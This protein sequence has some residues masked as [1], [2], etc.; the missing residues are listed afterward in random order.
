MCGNPIST[1]VRGAT[2]VATFGTAE[3]GGIS[4][5]LGDTAGGILGEGKGPPGAPNL[6]NYPGLSP[7]EL[8]AIKKQNISL[9]QLNSIISGDQATID[10][11]KQV[12]QGIS[13]LYNPDGTINQ[14]GLDSLKQRTQ[15]HI[16]LSNQIGDKA[17]GYLQS[18]FAP[19]G[20]GAGPAGTQADINQA[21]NQQ[22]L[23]ALNGKYKASVGLQ[24]DSAQQFKLLQEAAAKR[25]IKIDGDSFDS[26][27]SESTA[28][29][30]MISE[31]QK[32]YARNVDTEKQSILSRGGNLNLGRTQQAQTAGAQNFTL[33]NSV[34]AGGTPEQLGYFSGAGA[35]TSDSLAPV[36]GQ[37]VNGQSAVAN[38]FAQQRAGIYNSYLQQQQ[39]NY[40]AQTAQ[41]QADQ[42]RMGGIG[43]LVGT[44]G[45]A[46]IAGPVG[47]KVGSTVGG[48]A[49]T[50]SSS[51]G[52]GYFT[53]PYQ[54]F[55]PYQGIP[56][57]TYAPPSLD[58]YPPA[59][60]RMAMY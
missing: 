6:G 25:G 48:T 3:L 24:Q 46:L 44:I 29:I 27:T 20:Q 59:Q 18:Y 2:D 19:G 12:L 47:A 40:Q 36:I 42:A 21:E 60:P 13:G 56:S 26:A 38:P 54:G 16:E 43:S 22:Y 39:A 23:D 7:E 14:Q 55:Q 41:Y 5:K 32:N 50:S 9:D 4:K 51:G 52:T 31:F 8:D 49:G 30:K 15:Q 33:A 57:K 53:Q 35:L 10:K 11:N 1:I 58:L 34:A 28:G 37:Y 45:G 17:L